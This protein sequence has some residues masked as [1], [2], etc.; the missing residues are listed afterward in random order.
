MAQFPIKIKWS[1]RASLE[2]VEIHEY[3]TEKTT[4]LSADKYI[5]GILKAVEKLNQNPERYGFC[6][7]PKLQ[8]AK[9]RCINYQKKHIIFYQI[10]TNIEILAVIH[11]RRNP[12]FFDDI[13]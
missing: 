8:E 9:V 6:R 13:I 12:K 10:K 3:L 2:L 4:K 1:F 7:S 11:A 5:D